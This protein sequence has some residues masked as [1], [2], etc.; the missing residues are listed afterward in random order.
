[1][2]SIKRLIRDIPDFPKPGIIFKDITPILGDPAAMARITGAFER[3]FEAAK[4]TRIV[5]IESRGFI[6]G[7]VLATALELPFTPVRKPG[8]LPYD[9]ISVSYTLEYGQGS[10]EMHTDG[11]TSDDRVLIIDDLL[12]TG[13]T[14]AAACEL[15]E[16]V[17]A[18]V[19]GLGFV[20]ELQFL[21]GREKLGGHNVL[22][23]V[24]Y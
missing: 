1:M 10:L 6:F 18:Q 5:G 15:V 17:G 9:K 2:D 14:A 13:G 12:A 3:E 24:T 19:V 11:V 23:L 8:K 7:A 16:R 22:S 20:V 4:P 21:N